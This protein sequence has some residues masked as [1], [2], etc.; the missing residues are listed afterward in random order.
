V[1]WY[2]IFSNQSSAYEKSPRCEP[3]DLTDTSYNK[4]KSNSC[5]FKSPDVSNSIIL[6]TKTSENSSMNTDLCSELKRILR[7]K[8]TT[9]QLNET[10]F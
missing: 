2:H 1:C 10:T 9:A 8:T 6:L 3:T 7:L 5:S 4:T